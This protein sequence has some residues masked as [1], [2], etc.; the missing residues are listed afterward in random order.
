MN[1]LKGSRLLDRLVLTLVVVFAIGIGVLVFGG[2]LR[3][4]DIS[5]YLMFWMF[6]YPVISVVIYLVA[7]LL[8]RLVRH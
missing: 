1:H 2:M 3:S 7:M 5:G 6:G 8:I 4:V